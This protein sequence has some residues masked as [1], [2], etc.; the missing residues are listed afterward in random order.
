MSFQMKQRSGDY[1]CSQAWRL[2][3]GLSLYLVLLM[4]AGLMGSELT[5]TALKFYP[6]LFAD[7]QRRV[8]FLDQVT[9]QPPVLDGKLDDDCWSHAASFQGRIL[10]R[11]YGGS[12]DAI[13]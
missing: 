10:T 4:P 9:Q 5:F 11:S 8:L 13:S 7:H 1:H 6:D 2:C 12:N 3:I